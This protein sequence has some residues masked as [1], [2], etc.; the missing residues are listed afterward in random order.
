LS[1]PNSLFLKAFSLVCGRIVW[2]AVALVTLAGCSLLRPAPE[3]SV[4]DVGGFV[5]KGRLAVR[6]GD[7]GFSST[8][9]WQH[10]IGHDE[11]ELWGP[12]GQGRSRLVG[13]DSE[14]TIYTAKGEVLRE[15]NPEAGMKRWLGFS[16]PLSA[17]THWI[18]GEPAPGFPTADLSSDANGDVTLLEQLS[19]RI[20]FSAYEPRDDG[21]RLPGRIVA[22]RGDVKV[23]L[24]PG[25]WSFATQADLI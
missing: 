24:L 2:F 17:L 9:V 13:N 19:W 11:I 16:L 4:P 21:R 6:Q 3:L 23:T 18:L 5:V 14:V 10:A 8:F 15:P 22:V 7:D 20:E 25:E 1:L 12:L